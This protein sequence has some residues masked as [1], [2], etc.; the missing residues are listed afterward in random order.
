M[1][2]LIDF[3]GVI[4]K[5]SEG[6][7]DGWPYDPPMEGARHALN[8][9]VAAG[10]QVT[11]FT[12]RIVRYEGSISSV[13]VDAIEAWL[14]YYGFPKMLITRFKEPADLYIDDRG[15]RFESWDDLRLKILLRELEDEK[16]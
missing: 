2:I 1:K 9:L 14:A 16:S 6:W 3:D 4:H 15:F 12:A 5:Y 8:C 7:R 13:M 10:H 11:I